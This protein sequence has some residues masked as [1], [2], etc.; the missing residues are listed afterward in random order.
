[1]EEAVHGEFERVLVRPFEA[2]T[3]D[4]EWAQATER[5]LSSRLAAYVEQSGRRGMQ[6]EGIECR[7]T[8]CRMQLRYSDV[9]ARSAAQGDLFHKRVF[10]V[11]GCAVHSIEGDDEAEE[12][13]T[14][15]LILEY[16]AGHCEPGECLL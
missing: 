12:A 15:T 5:E 4:A 10:G 8:R 11:T 14:Q 16:D 13:A 1:M 9:G 6:L 3:R 7:E 2:E